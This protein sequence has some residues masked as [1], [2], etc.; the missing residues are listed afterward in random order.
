MTKRK[1]KTARVT[2]RLR[3]LTERLRDIYAG[4]M[5]EV[6]PRPWMSWEFDH[7][8]RQ[9]VIGAIRDRLGITERDMVFED[10]SPLPQELDDPDDL[11][12]FLIEAGLWP[13]RMDAAK[14]CKAKAMGGP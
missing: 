1:T 14:R 7:K 13:K 6:P 11:A 9:R 4:A 3:D 12:R 10:Y 2:K 8:H 5:G